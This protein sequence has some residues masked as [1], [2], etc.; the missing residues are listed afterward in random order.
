MLLW[1]Y[2]EFFT[3]KKD[4]PTYYSSWHCSCHCRSLSNKIRKK[5]TAKSVKSWSTWDWS[6][7]NLDIIH[8]ISLRPGGLGGSSST[9]RNGMLKSRHTFLWKGQKLNYYICNDIV[10]YNIMITWDLELS[11]TASNLKALLVPVTGHSVHW[12]LHIPKS[13][14]YNWV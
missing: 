12:M 7:R 4:L 8:S 3:F 1:K 5:V 9:F 10:R 6:T 2:E 14:K 11:V 13:L